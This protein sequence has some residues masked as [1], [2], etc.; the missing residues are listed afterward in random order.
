MR[1][2][3]ACFRLLSIALGADASVVCVAVS[4]TSSL[5]LSRFAITDLQGRMRAA[6][7][8]PLASPLSAQILN[9][10]P[11]LTNPLTAPTLTLNPT[12]NTP[13]THSLT[14][15]I[16]FYSPLPATTTLF[17]TFSTSLAAP[18]PPH[19]LYPSPLTITPATSLTPPPPTPN[20]PTDCGHHSSPDPDRLPQSSPKP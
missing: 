4:N 17:L 14:L 2:S 15:T 19:L 16:T 1:R 5:R 11:T 12:L 13:L 20:L 3:L 8:L 7:T 6:H 10:A 9:L 18:L